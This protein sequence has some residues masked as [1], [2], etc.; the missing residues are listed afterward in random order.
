MDKYQELIKELEKNLLEL[1]TYKARK[2]ELFSYHKAQISKDSENYRKGYHRYYEG[3]NKG[4]Y[5]AHDGVIKKIKT[6][7]DS[8]KEENNNG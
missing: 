7:L 2:K 1:E 4:A 3:I 5:Y 8:A 6:L